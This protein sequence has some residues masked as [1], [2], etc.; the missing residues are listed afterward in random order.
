MKTLFPMVAAALAFAGCM[1][2]GTCKG[3][4]GCA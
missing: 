4:C 1:T 3:K 2:T